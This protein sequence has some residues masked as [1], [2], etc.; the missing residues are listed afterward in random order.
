VTTPTP[1]R[2]RPATAVPLLCAAIG[3]AATAAVI[4]RAG[5]HQLI[6]VM[7]SIGWRGLVVL[8][9]SQIAMFGILGVAWASI[10]PGGA[11][12]C[13][14]LIW[15]RMIRDAAANCLPFSAVG[16]MVF[17]TRALALQGVTW[18][19][20]A[21]SVIVDTTAEFIAQI[22]FTI[23]GFA[24]LLV[25]APHSPLTLPLALVLVIAVLAVCGFVRAQSG[26][27]RL[28]DLLA[29]RIGGRW[30]G[31][32]DGPAARI[33]EALGGLY[34]RPGVPSLSVAWHLVGWIASG[35]DGW[36]ALHLVGAEASLAGAMGIEALLRLAMVAG[37][38]V[39]AGI[40]VQEVAYPALAAAFGVPAD[41]A[42]AVAL[43]RRGRSIAF[44][45]P[46]LL[47]S[48]TLELRRTRNVANADL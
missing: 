28:L 37:F 17:G 6:D 33:A 16:G 13:P 40:G 46:V 41:M 7:L 24:L 34:D 14:G 19:L 48:Q 30:L 22:V 25:R 1:A 21:A 4:Y 27:T 10:L 31:A 23:I 47:L 43:L 32:S 12:R 42:L 35:I 20:A 8:I 18:P 39:P 44:G 2:H 5:L 45:L 36:I 15:A 29:R 3:V 11:S 26:M 9:L 38:I